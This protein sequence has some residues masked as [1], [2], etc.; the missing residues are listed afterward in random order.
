MEKPFIIERKW[1]AK[2]RIFRVESLHLQFSNGQQRNYEKVYGR[3]NAVMVLGVTDQQEVLLVREY[4]VG[5]ED[6]YTA[7]PRGV[8]DVGETAIEAANRELQEEVGYAARKL[9]VLC[10]LTSSPGYSEERMSIV[11]AEG[12]YPKKMSGDEPEPLQIIRCSLDAL[13]G[14]LNDSEVHEVRTVTAIHFLKQLYS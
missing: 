8:I 2:S 3:G 10:S 14:L 5:I 13:D 11:L 12:L 1:V 9:R 7:F 6:Y 4:G